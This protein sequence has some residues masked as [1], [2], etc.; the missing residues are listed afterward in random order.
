MSYTDRGR[1]LVPGGCGAQALAGTQA[2]LQGTGKRWLYI[3]HRPRV[4]LPLATPPALQSLQ[5]LLLSLTFERDE[6]IVVETACSPEPNET[7]ETFRSY[8]FFFSPQGRGRRLRT[9]INPTGGPPK[10][11]ERRGGARRG[12]VKWTASSS[13]LVCCNCYQESTDLSQHQPGPHFLGGF[14]ARDAGQG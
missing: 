11:T 9:M 5:L 7:L 13:H 10:M 8:Y 4:G 14:C 1:T 3:S 2:S 6:R 12:R